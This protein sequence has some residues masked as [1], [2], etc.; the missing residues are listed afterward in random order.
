[1][2]I[3]LNE[4]QKAGLDLAISRYYAGYPYTCIAG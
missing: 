1:M 3:T 4:K 2:A